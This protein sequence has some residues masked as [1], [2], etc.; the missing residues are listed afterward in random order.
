MPIGSRATADQ[1]RRELVRVGTELLVATLTGGLRDPTPQHGETTYAAKLD[2]AELELDWTQPTDVLDR[3]V[4]VGG[5]WTRFRGKRLKVLGAEPTPGGSLGH[6]AL[7][8][9]VVG[10]GDGALRLVEVQPE[11]KAPMSADAWVRGLH[12]Q[13]DERLG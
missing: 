12:A 4:R 2:P 7:N 13:P 5:A 10:T 11:G 9:T 8:G 1:L 6:A 3:V